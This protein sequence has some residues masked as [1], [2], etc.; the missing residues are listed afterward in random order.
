QVLEPVPVGYLGVAL[1]FLAFAPRSIANLCRLGSQIRV[2]EQLF[3]VAHP[4]GPL[5]EPIAGDRVSGSAGRSSSE[6]VT[7]VPTTV[8]TARRRAALLRPL[9]TLGI[10]AP[11][12]ATR[13]LRSPLSSL[14][15]TTGLLSLF[16]A[17]LI[18]AVPLAGFCALSPLL[19]LL[20]LLI[21]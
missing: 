13:P 19:S 12:Q 11:S 20:P 4:V 2:V 7:P 5:A 18:P 14:V 1:E 21:S 8:G 16:L 3:H 15:A 17:S 9:F 10:I 6:P